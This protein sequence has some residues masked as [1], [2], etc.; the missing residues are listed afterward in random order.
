[1]KQKYLGETERVQRSYCIALDSDL[2]RDLSWL[3]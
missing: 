1:M 2:S 3:L